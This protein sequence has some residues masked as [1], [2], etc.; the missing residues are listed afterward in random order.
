MPS[1]DLE[2]IANISYA[3]LLL[4]YI[5]KDI[6]WLRILTVFSLFFEVPYYYFQ[7]EP[8]WAGIGWDTAFILINVYWITYLG[9]ERRPV[10]FTDEQKRI[11]ETSLNRLRPHHARK[12][13]KTGKSKSIAEN[14]TI[15][16]QGEKMD[17]IALITDGNVALRMNDRT[18][19]ELGPGHFIGSAIF[20]DGRQDS[21]TIAHIVAVEPT[22]MITWN[23]K[24][25]RKM[26]ENDNQLSMAIEASLGLDMAQLLERAWNRESQAT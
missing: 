6:L 24:E 13:F 1:F 19:E 5:M 4:S 20:L 22:Q 18:V 2:I 10:R 3:L 26:I 21:Q 15:A 23:H 16:E 12:L 25:L 11:Y 8:L 14:E 7:S 9:I 17:E